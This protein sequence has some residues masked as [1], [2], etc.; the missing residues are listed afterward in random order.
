MCD[1]IKKCKLQLNSVREGL[2]FT[3]MDLGLLVFVVLKLYHFNITANRD[4]NENKYK[5]YLAEF[6]HK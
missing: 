3:S 5:A 2:Y 6:K 1:K 4:N